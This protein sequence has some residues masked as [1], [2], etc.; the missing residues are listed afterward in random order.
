MTEQTEAEVQK[1]ETS[2]SESSAGGPTFNFA[3]GAGTPLKE[4]PSL[5]KIRARSIAMRQLE[6][7]IEPLHRL[8]YGR[9]GRMGERWGALEEFCGFPEY[10]REE[11]VDRLGRIAKRR[12]RDFVMATGMRINVSQKLP[13]LAQDVTAFLMSPQ[14][15]GVIDPE[16][17]AA[18][19]KKGSS[20]KSTQRGRKTAKRPASTRSRRA[21]G[22]ERKT[23]TKRLARNSTLRA[24]SLESPSDDTLRVAIFRRVLFT[25]QTERSYLT[26]KVLRLELQE[27][28]GDLEHRKAIIKEAAAECVSALISAESAAI[29]FTNSNMSSTTDTTIKTNDFTQPGTVSSENGSPA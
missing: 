13:K 20:K 21:N 5:K 9:P 6:T 12:L 29:A 24:A 8:V 25:P 2:T 15:E 28:F 19:P 22:S 14:S 3:E 11:V 10:K 1:R 7:S 4:L 18:K 23:P 16:L 17:E 27:K 26:T